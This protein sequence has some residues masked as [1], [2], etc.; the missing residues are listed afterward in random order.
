MKENRPFLNPDL[1]LN[2]LAK[3]ISIPVHYISQILNEILNQHFY[4]YI[5]HYRIEEAKRMF[6]NPTS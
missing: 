1:S 4:D 3:D 6:Q 5:N 2:Q